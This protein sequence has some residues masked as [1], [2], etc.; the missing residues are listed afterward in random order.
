MPEYCLLSH[1]CLLTC[2]AL[3]YTWQW[4]APVSTRQQLSL[5]LS[6]SSSTQQHQETKPALQLS[7]PPWYSLTKC[8]YSLLVFH[9][10]IRQHSQLFPPKLRSSNFWVLSASSYFSYPRTYDLD[11]F[12]SVF[13]MAEK[14]AVCQQVTDINVV[15]DIN[16]LKETI[17]ATLHLL[18]LKNSPNTQK[19]NIQGAKKTWEKPFSF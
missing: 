14:S 18:S 11:V 7:R 8:N 19:Q 16:D 4:F 15:I 1:L 12:S 2:T 5:L 13:P 9:L 17:F 6:H 10:H 3:L